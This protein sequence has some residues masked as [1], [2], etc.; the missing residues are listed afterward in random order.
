MAIPYTTGLD[1]NYFIRRSR[2]LMAYAVKGEPEEGVCPLC[3]GIGRLVSVEEGRRVVR[4]C[5][6]AREEQARQRLKNTG[7]PRA[8]V[9][10]CTFAAFAATA[11]LLEKMKRTVM[12]YA[13]K[14]S[15]WL[16]LA[17]QEG[18]GKTH[19]AVAAAAAL[20]ERDYDVCWMDWRFENGWLKRVDADPGERLRRIRRLQQCQVV[21]IDDLLRS[22]DRP[23]TADLNLAMEILGYRYDN[24]LP[25]LLTTQWTPKKLSGMSTALTDR[26]LERSRES[27]AVIPAD[28][29]Y[30]MRLR[31]RQ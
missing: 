11:P 16:L 20:S 31:S 28:Q 10:S 14:P 2:Q 30:N 8:L 4:P 3:E 15:G 27:L 25:T 21:L 13:E 18:S 5:S 6:C 22:A 12:A 17:G 9:E 7:L 1:E 24:G 29:T 19:L 23:S 26:I